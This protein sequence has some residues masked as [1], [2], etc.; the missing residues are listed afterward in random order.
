MSMI[1]LPSFSSIS[2]SI[3]GLSMLASSAIPNSYLPDFALQMCFIIDSSFHFRVFI[4]N[5]CDYI[6]HRGV[7]FFNSYFHQ[8]FIK[9]FVH[10]A[11]LV[12]MIE[13]LYKMI[14]LYIIKNG[15]F[16]AHDRNDAAPAGAAAAFGESYSRFFGKLGCDFA[17]SIV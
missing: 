5:P 14:L 10:I 6:I 4:F 13:Q 2:L 16:F 15:P 3:P 11:F 12:C 7:Y 9:Y 1:S 17:Q 8:R